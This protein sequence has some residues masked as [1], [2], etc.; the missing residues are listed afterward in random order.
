MAQPAQYSNPSMT[1][2][3]VEQRRQ[4]AMS[5]M[6]QGT[7]ASPVG[8][9]T[10]GLARVLQGGMG[11][12]YGRTASDAERQ[13]VA[14]R[15][16][17]MQ[18]AVQNPQAAAASGAGDPWTTDQ[19]TAIGGKVISQKMEQGSPDYQLRLQKGRADLAMAPL[20]RQMKEAQIKALG[21]KDAVN[22]AIAKM[23]SDGGGGG[24][25]APGAPQAGGMPQPGQPPMS[26]PP[27]GGVQP[28]SFAPQAPGGDPNLVLAQTAPQPMPGGPPQAAPQQDMV[29]TPYGPR[30]RDQARKMAGAMLLSPQ[31]A[32]AGKAI[33][34]SMGTGDRLGKEGANEIDKK[35]I[36]ASENL[37]NLS[38]VREQFR[39][40][41]QQIEN[42][43]GMAWTAFADKFKAGKSFIKP[44]DREQL[45]AFAAYRSDALDT[46]NNY[47]KAITG[48][49]MTDGEARRILGALPA[50]GEGV[51][52]GDGPTSF[53]SKLDAAFDKTAAAVARYRY[54]KNEG[55][56][57][58][59]IGIEQMK[60]IVRN[61][62]RQIESE[63]IRANP[64]MD[65]SALPQ[66]VTAKIKQEFGI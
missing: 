28:Q 54:A 51:F 38:S 59:T 22:E 15:S 1:P 49:A 57:W 55:K 60:S 41:F 50:V 37:T 52:D 7:D 66:A 43:L 35:M 42:R 20:D 21:Q 6:Q 23:L 8:H 2:K 64:N 62:G 14:S 39:P 9:W 18:Q 30:T 17:F 65:R 34:D 12:Y 11:G 24:M 53:K 27:Q 63:M 48:A 31:Y 26:Q 56:D 32:A 29:Q 33:L 61:R 3:D 25:P 13:G 36:A 19:A 4:L 58:Q 40:E 46:M 16:A 5:L 47:I 10:Q 45:E 44:E